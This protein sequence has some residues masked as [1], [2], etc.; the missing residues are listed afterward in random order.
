MSH[1]RL[2]YS[3]YWSNTTRPSSY[4][5]IMFSIHNLNICW[6]HAEYFTTSAWYSF[7]YSEAHLWHQL[8]VTL[9]DG[10]LCTSSCCGPIERLWYKR[11]GCGTTGESPCI[12][13]S[14]GTTG[15]SSCSR[16]AW[17]TAEGWFCFRS[18]CGKLRMIF[19][20][21]VRLW[22]S[23]SIILLQVSCEPA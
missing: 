5:A 7:P 16:S 11:S 8:I 2:Q 9:R 12:R 6:M 13:S 20:C 3:R 14:C 22:A 23:W 1:R 21:Q 17:W 19:L 18:G 15:G 4:P 10:S